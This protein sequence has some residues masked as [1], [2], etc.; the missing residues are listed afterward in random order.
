MTWNLDTTHSNI[1]FSARHMVMSN[2]RGTFKEFAVTADVDENDVTKSTGVV[3]IQA[4]S[5]DTGLGDRD[6]HLR[7]ADFFAV[8]QHPEITFAVKRIEKKGGDYRLIGDLSIR[9]T[10]R[11]VTLDAEIAGPFKDPWGN[12]KLGISAEGKINR[13]DFGLNWNVALEMGGVL[14]GETVK[15]GID[16][17]LAKAAEKLEVVAAG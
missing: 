15:L 10:T 12:A 8:E 11:E 1:S 13:K 5:L 9:E 4:A 3:T 2:V 17:Q 14:V 6:N 7:S 16:L